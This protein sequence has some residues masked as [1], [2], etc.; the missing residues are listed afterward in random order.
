LDIFNE[1]AALSPSIENKERNHTLGTSWGN[2]Y[3]Y[4]F[5]TFG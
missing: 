3:T 5:K 2:G 1:N 4:D